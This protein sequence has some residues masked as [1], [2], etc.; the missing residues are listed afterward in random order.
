MDRMTISGFSMYI[1][2][3]SVEAEGLD[4]F[5]DMICMRFKEEAEAVVVRM[6][7]VHP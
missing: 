7:L 5:N 1:L 6:V 2:I 3:E 4:S